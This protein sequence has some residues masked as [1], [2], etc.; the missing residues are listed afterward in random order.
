MRRRWPKW[1]LLTILTLSPDGGSILPANAEPL[2]P[3]V[4]PSPEVRGSPF[5]GP[6]VLTTSIRGQEYSKG[7][8]ELDHL[9]LNLH[10]KFTNVHW[11][12]TLRMARPHF[13][14]LASNPRFNRRYATRRASA[15]T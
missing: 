7:D 5:G 15:I 11:P 12:Q 13:G 3:A 4:K 14:L 10:L 9:E 2:G 1:I 6:L 8:E